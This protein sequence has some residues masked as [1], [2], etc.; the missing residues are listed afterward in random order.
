MLG[1][2]PQSLNKYKAFKYLSHFVI[3]LDLALVLPD[4]GGSMLDCCQATA[5]RGISC[6]QAVGSDCKFF[7]LVNRKMSVQETTV[8]KVC[9]V[10]QIHTT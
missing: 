9:S 4:L 5:N 2:P 3:S 6:Q 8:Y 1:Y 7:C 10:V